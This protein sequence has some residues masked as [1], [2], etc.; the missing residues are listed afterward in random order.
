MY[1]CVYLVGWVMN[2]EVKEEAG[3]HVAYV[4]LFMGD[5]SIVRLAS[6]G[7]NI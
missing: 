7:Q 6:S 4:P 2:S 1:G 5:T 3:T